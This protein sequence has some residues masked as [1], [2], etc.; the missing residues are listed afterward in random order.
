MRLLELRM[1]CANAYA[2]GTWI[3]LLSPSCNPSPFF[4]FDKIPRQFR[5]VARQHFDE[6]HSKS[7]ITQTQPKKSDT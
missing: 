5:L 3:L 7:R 1:K 6:I 4:C 2:A